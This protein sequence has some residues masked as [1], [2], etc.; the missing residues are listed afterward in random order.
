[1]A[2]TAKGRDARRS[3]SQATRSKSIGHYILGRTIGEGTFGKVKLGTHILTGEKVA[4]KILE[5]DRISDVADVERVAREIHILKMLRHPNIIQLYEIIETPKQLYLIMEF[6][7]G[8][9]LFDYIVART[10]VKEKEACR[11]FLQLIAGLEYIHKLG[12]VHRDLK[13]ENLL[14]DHQRSI[15]IVDFGLSNT[16]KPGETLK[17]ACGSPCYAAPEMIA[18]K[19]Y[20]G[21]R[22]DIW[23]CG[24]ILFA[25]ICGYLPF[26]DPNTGQLYKKIMSGEYQSPKFISPEARDLLAG[27]LN[28]D[29]DKRFTIDQIRQHPWCAQVKV[30]CSPGI[31]VGYNPIPV[32]PTILARLEEFGLNTETGR[33]AIEGNRH[34]HLTTTYYLLL[35][36]FV[37]SGGAPT[38]SLPAPIPAQET[39]AIDISFDGIAQPAR[40]RRYVELRSVRNNSSTGGSRD[41]PPAFLRTTALNESQVAPATLNATLQPKGHSMSPTSARE[42]RVVGARPILFASSGK[43]AVAAITPRPPSRATPTAAKTFRNRAYLRNKTPERRGTA[44]RLEKTAPVPKDALNS[45]ADETAEFLEA[46]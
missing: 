32:D 3:S 42:K 25:L 6:C 21:L 22:V 31:L 7:S 43:D 44:S 34:N 23:S 45:T 35:K 40:H 14:L 13:P 30:E 19:R 9:E 26:E 5:K 16:Y 8:G 33:K 12:I 46:V 17:T 24:V 41:P 4:I 1:M 11:F 36:R 29:P 15:K 10:K 18:G 27:I 37:Q 38:A 39:P 28:T 2:E 20:I